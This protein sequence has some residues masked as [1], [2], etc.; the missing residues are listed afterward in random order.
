M[1]RVLTG[2]QS[3]GVPHLGNLLGAI[4]P[5]IDLANQPG[6]EAFFFIADLHSLT[7]IHNPEVLQENTYST[8]AAWLACGFDTDKGYFYRQSDIPEV[9][10]LTWYLTCHFPYMRLARATS[11]KDKSDN[12]GQVSSGLFFYPMLMAAD[13]L[14]YDAEMVP[15]GKDQKQHLEFTREV[16]EKINNQH[17]KDVLVVPEPI[18]KSEVMTVP[19]VSKDK[20]GKFM[21]MSK[22]YGN[23]VIIFQSDKKLRKCI[24]SI[25]TDSTPMEDPKNP[26]QDIVY[27]LYKLMGTSEQTAEL[28]ERY[29]KGGMGYGHAK[30]ALY[31]LIVEK[32]GD[33]REKYEYYMG[34]KKLIDDKLME[35][36][37][38]AGIVAHEV[39][40]RVREKLG[41]KKFAY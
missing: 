23:E 7:T 22:S 37:E 40:S 31:E 12:L 8:A 2:I 25:Q 34:N 18:I 3:T 10:E 38:K 5:G 30:Q 13:I 39:L 33:A 36:A 29:L 16:A 17:G 19:G 9:T 28:R 35:G 4:L 27:H 14:M 11:F 32:F 21:K 20:D 1:A 41:Y 15:V 26:D 6:N 24:M